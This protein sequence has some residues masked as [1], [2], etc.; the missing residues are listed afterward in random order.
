MKNRLFFFTSLFIFCFAE[1]LIKP[2]LC[3]AVSGLNLV[4]SPLPITLTAQPGST[5][6]A[7]LKVKNGGTDNE[8][9]HVGLMKFNA[10]NNDGQPRL[11]DR[12]KG[13]DYFDWVSFSDNDFTIAPNEWKTITATINVPSTAAFGYYYAIIFGRKD[14]GPAAT[15][16]TKIEGAVS[17]LV[18][19]NVVSP[20]AVSNIQVVEFNSDRKVYEFL[21]AKFSLKLKNSG[22][23]F[24]APHGDIFIDKGKKT[25][26]AILA[27]NE[28]Q[29]NVLPGSYRIFDT[30]WSD[31][32]PTFVQRIEN[33]K[34][35][36]DKK[37]NNILDLK[38]DFNQLS[39]LRFGKFTAHLLLVYDN[40]TRDV[41]IEAVTSFWVIPWRL[42]GGALIVLSLISAGLWSLIKPI[43]KKFKKIKNKED[44]IK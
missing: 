33:G 40:G 25:D 43:I 3:Q 29:G 35:V 22:N 17:V 18:L 4:I 16:A 31:G 9:L 7:Q 30:D 36:T 12:E 32:F 1:F 10:Y 38:W 20:N 11:L 34:V 2:T 26:L 23:I 24:I 37:G 27:V 15:T 28:V 19:L 42:L 8:T 6:S 5:V 44:E 41:P 21:P 13:D 14:E 39:K